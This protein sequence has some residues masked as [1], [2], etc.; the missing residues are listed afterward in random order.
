MLIKKHLKLAVASKEKKMFNL[1]PIRAAADV[2]S[3]LIF[4][5]IVYAAV[6]WFSPADLVIEQTS[7]ICLIFIPLSILEWRRAKLRGGVE[8]IH[9]FL[10]GLILSALLLTLDCS[11]IFHS[12]VS[13]SG[14]PGFSNI[15]VL[16]TIFSVFIT[17]MSLVGAIR[18]VI[19]QVLN[20]IAG[21]SI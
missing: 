15:T 3:G 17:L 19:I 20:R 6:V 9:W 16:F 11:T 4:Y 13:N 7:I 1:D 2:I 12:G 18:A 10:A 14:C 21:R 5:L 8:W